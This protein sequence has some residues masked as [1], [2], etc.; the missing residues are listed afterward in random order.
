MSLIGRN[1][2]LTIAATVL[3]LMS[4]KEAPG[5]G[6]IVPVYYPPRVA[7]YYSAPTVS[8][9]ATPTV[10]YY[11]P[12]V[13]YYPAPPMGYNAPPVVSYYSAGPVTTMRYGPFGRPRTTVYYPS[14]V[15]P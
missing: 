9:Y 5:Q 15:L 6:V 14:Y 4:A 12:R 7:Y 8:Y 13:A 2:A 10:T 3:L 1:S 11:S